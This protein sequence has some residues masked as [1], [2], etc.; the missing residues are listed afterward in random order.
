VDPQSPDEGI[1]GQDTIYFY[2]HYF[3]SDPAWETSFTDMPLKVTMN[4][5]SRPDTI[6]LGPSST[7]LQKLW[8]SGAISSRSFGFYLG[9]G[10][11]RAKGVINGSTIFGGYD[12]GRFEGTVYNY[13]LTPNVANP[14]RVH[15]SSITLDDPTG[16]VRNVPLV[17]DDGFDAE[18]STEQYP[19][20]FPPS[21]TSRFVDALAAEETDSEDGSLRVTKPFNGTMTITLSSGFSIKL[22]PSVVA[23]VSNISPVQA[24]SNSSSSSGPFILGGS[25]LSQVYLMVNYD[26]KS[27]HLAQ[28]VP[29][30]KFI[31]TKTMCPRVVPQPYVAP[32]VGFVTGGL[33]GAVIGG[34]IGGSALATVAI[35]FCLSW[36]RKRNTKHVRYFDG[37]KG[38]VKIHQFDVEDDGEEG[39]QPRRP[40]RKVGRL[41]RKS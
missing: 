39:G 16:I 26:D 21:V 40:W 11:D 20:S 12:A 24:T 18:I 38:G 19:M 27:F 41:G 37:R 28:A 29:E 2:T 30:A 32:K 10:F 31:V 6:G 33:I 5:S 13:T 22:A 4:G 14:F 36:R 34:V 17:S 23:N 9:T 1:F 3:Q 35:C 7:V 15:V 25:W 8:S